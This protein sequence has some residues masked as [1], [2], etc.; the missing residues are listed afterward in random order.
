MGFI[1]EVIHSRQDVTSVPL[2]MT[3]NAPTIIAVN[4]FFTGFTLLVVFARIY[5]RTIMLKT[6]GTDDY[7]IVAAMVNYP[8]I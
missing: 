8:D 6:F 7:V 4:G 5:V 3:S 1:R 2:D